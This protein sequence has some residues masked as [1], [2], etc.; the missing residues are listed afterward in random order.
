M[1]A[2]SKSKPYPSDGLKNEAEYRSILLGSLSAFTSGKVAGDGYLKPAKRS[3]ADLVVTEHTLRRA[4]AVL[5]KLANSF[6]K[7]KYRVSVAHSDGSYTRK[8]LGD[9]KSRLKRSVLEANLWS[10]GRP[11][12]VFIGGTA[13]GLTIYEQTSSQ[14][15]VFV[16]GRYIP[17]HE[18]E[19]TKRGKRYQRSASVYVSTHYTPSKKLCLRAYSPFSQVDWSHTWTEETA[20]L[21]T[22]LRDIVSSLIN[23]AKTLTL[24][25]A[26]AQRKADEERKRWQAEYEISNARYER[27][28]IIKAREDSLQN[29]LK[30]INKWS[31]DRR[32]QDFFEDITAR[33]ADM[34]DEAREEVLLKVQ[35][36][37]DLLA[38]NDSVGALLSWAVPPKTSSE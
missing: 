22:Q 32:L 14:E 3:L 24:Q 1:L 16:G 5:V 27:S 19:T 26:S 25:V 30:I 34:S 13:I 20:S 23:Q 8:P 15:M 2:G 36:A 29:L 37:K 6:R 4:V 35:D 21:S 38:S 28:R 11:T 18:P 31:E 7:D 9:D 17:Y 33:A 12:L 10:P